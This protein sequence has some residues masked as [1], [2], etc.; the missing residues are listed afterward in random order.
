MKKHFVILLQLI[1]KWNKCCSD[2]VK[3]AESYL[4]NS[5]RQRLN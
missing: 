3:N 5:V 2:L 4:K 1:L